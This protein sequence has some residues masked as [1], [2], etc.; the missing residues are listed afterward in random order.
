MKK[1]L[2]IKKTGIKEIFTNKI[3]NILGETQTKEDRRKTKI[4]AII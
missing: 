1:G 3:P 2:K 4:L